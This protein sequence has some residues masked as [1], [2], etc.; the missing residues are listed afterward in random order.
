MTIDWRTA[1]E[2]ARWAAYDPKC[3]WT[4]Y[5]YRPR[6]WC[7]DLGSAWAT[8]RQGKEAAFDSPHYAA[9]WRL[10]LQERPAQKDGKP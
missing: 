6:V 2:W 10:S 9:N 5:E 1:P 4:W 7:C 3:G 8:I